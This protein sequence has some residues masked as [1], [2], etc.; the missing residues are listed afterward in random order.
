MASQQLQQPNRARVAKISQETWESYKSDISRLYLD[1]RKTLDQVRLVMEESLGFIATKAQYIR[2][3]NEVWR[4][5]KNINGS[6]L[7]CIDTRAR[8]R[9]RDGK[10]TGVKLGNRQLDESELR[11]KRS[12]H[13]VSVIEQHQRRVAARP[14]EKKTEPATPEGMEIFTPT[15][16]IPSPQNKD[17][18]VSGTQDH[19]FLNSM[20]SLSKYSPSPGTPVTS[21]YCPPVPI[22]ELARLDIALPSA[23]FSLPIFARRGGS[24]AYYHTLAGSRIS[25]SVALYNNVFQTTPGVGF[26]LL[27]EN[28]FK[29]IFE[30]IFALLGDC[31][32]VQPTFTLLQCL[33]IVNLGSYESLVRAS[34]KYPAIEE[35]LSH[36]AIKDVEKWLSE[37]QFDL[38]ESSQSKIEIIYFLKAYMIRLSNN[39]EEDS[40]RWIMVDQ[41]LG[42]GI[43]QNHIRIIEMILQEAR[44]RKSRHA[45]T[46]S[47]ALTTNPYHYSTGF[48]L[49]VDKFAAEPPHSAARV[50]DHAIVDL[51]LRIGFPGEE[52]SSQRKTLNNKVGTTA[53]Q[54]ATE[55]GNIAICYLLLRQGFDVNVP[56]IS[57][58]S[59]SLLWTAVALDFPNLASDLVHV[60]NATV[61]IRKKF[62]FTVRN[63][64]LLRYIEELLFNENALCAHLPSTFGHKRHE[65]LGPNGLCGLFLVAMAYRSPVVAEY[66]AKHICLES[67]LAN[68]PRVDSVLQLS[69]QKINISRTKRLLKSGVDIH[70]INSI[71]FQDSFTRGP[72]E[73]TMCILLWLQR[74]GL[75]DQI[76]LLDYN[77][78]GGS[79]ERPQRENDTLGSTPGL[80]QDLNTRIISKQ[81]T[82]GYIYARDVEIY[83][84]IATIEV[85]VEGFCPND[86]DLLRNRIII[87]SAL[88]KR[89]DVF[90][91]LGRDLGVDI[92][93]QNSNS[94]L[95]VSWDLGY[96]PGLEK[97]KGL[98]DFDEYD[99][100]SGSIIR[101]HNKTE[102]LQ[103]GIELGMASSLERFSRKLWRVNAKGIVEGLVFGD[104][105]F[106]RED[107]TNFERV[108]DLVRWNVP[109]QY[110]K[111]QCALSIEIIPL[112]TG[113]GLLSLLRLAVHCDA[114]ETVQAIFKS[115]RGL[116]LTWEI[117][118]EAAW[119]AGPETFDLIVGQYWISVGDTHK[120]VM[121][122]ELIL[123]ITIIAGNLYKVINILPFTNIDRDYGRE[124]T[125]LGVATFLGRLDICKVLRQSGASKYISKYEE[126]AG[127]RGNFAIQSILRMA[128]HERGEA[129][130]GKEM[131]DGV[132]GLTRLD[133]P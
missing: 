105:N 5:K 19:L 86:R 121:S 26:S 38:L 50:G 102:Y 92:F 7:D 125:P 12:R 84:I 111:Q 69:I 119:F 93:P 80:I 41:I 29:E 47:E 65:L 70:A 59:P 35:V 89:L 32:T 110:Q 61:E 9:A 21:L 44:L 72:Y 62:D 54:Y 90:F 95:R 122:F 39:I 97:L 116:K 98:F 118:H 11:R 25:S 51:L 79:L 115:H 129:R 83:R 114:Y 10:K 17:L 31:E 117:L 124:R 103:T 28:Y 101:Y 48:E 77:E 64:S 132:Q 57:D 131:M 81:K 96:E 53:I 33:L 128:I 2:M 76:G 30:G 123:L 56:P 18:V 78:H 120:E 108:I 106:P 88:F 20:V 100:K 74:Q 82:P 66:I 36:E 46:S 58:F 3:V 42:S 6:D 49:I 130:S 24:I 113:V 67:E 16:S 85:L 37:I 1:E 8:K 91:I 45:N 34:K 87:L 15:P 27:F 99:E 68:H 14:D 43:I 63:N 75:I 23:S 71:A 126:E 112:L 94:D 13:H 73:Y 22:E 133:M 127:E 107:T 52:A 104:W 55:Y 60:Y 109:L 40:T 4:L